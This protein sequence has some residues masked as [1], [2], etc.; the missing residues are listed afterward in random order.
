MHQ[1]LFHGNYKSFES[2][3]INIAANCGTKK[4]TTAL[5]KGVQPPG[6]GFRSCGKDPG[7]CISKNYFCDKRFNCINDAL[8]EVPKSED[9]KFCQND[10]E[11]LEKG[12]KHDEKEE[13]E[14]SIHVD[15]NALNTISWILIGVCSALGLLLIIILSIGC[16]RNSFCQRQLHDGECLEP[17]PVP[18]NLAEL[19][20]QPIQTEQNIYLPLQTLTEP[21][22]IPNS[23]IGIHP[24]NTNTNPTSLPE[25][26]PPAYDSLFPERS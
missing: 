18:A 4:T 7:P 26:P 23:D 6:P 9:E 14:I 8:T 20:A 25:D 12:A 3:H 5:I 13:E 19:S 21:Q 1:S 11:I 15:K 16:T 22:I 10:E 24:P 17:I 2:I